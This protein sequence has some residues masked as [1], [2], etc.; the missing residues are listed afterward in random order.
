MQSSDY[1]S[2]YSAF[3]GFTETVE[4]GAQHPTHG[5]VP[6]LNEEW[7]SSYPISLPKD[8]IECLDS[9]NPV[10]PAVCSLA[11]ELKRDAR[12]QIQREEQE[13]QRLEDQLSQLRNRL[14]SLKKS[15]CAYDVILSPF[16]RVPHDILHN[17]ALY[18][19]PTEHPP[20]HDEDVFP[21]HMTPNL[22]TPTILSHTSAQWRSTVHSMSSLWQ[23]MCIDCTVWGKASLEPLIWQI[24]R[25]ESLSKGQ[26]L[27]ILLDDWARCKLPNKD[28]LNPNTTAHHGLL[29]VLDW[30]LITWT[31]A[32]KRLTKFMVRPF[33]HTEVLDT[34]NDHCREHRMIQLPKI[35]TFMLVQ[36]DEFA[37]WHCTYDL[38]T[39]HL[40]ALSGLFPN[41]QQLWFE[42]QSIVADFLRGSGDGVY[43]DKGFPKA[44]KALTV[45]YF[46]PHLLLQYRD[47]IALLDACPHLKWAS[48]PIHLVTSEA[49]S[50]TAVTDVTHD[51]LMELS[52]TV[53]PYCT[54]HILQLFERLKFPKLIRLYLDFDC[55]FLSLRLLGSTHD[56]H[57]NP[58]RFKG[59]FPSISTLQIYISGEVRGG[60]RFETSAVFPLLRSI[61]SVVEFSFASNNLQ[62]ITPVWDFINNNEEDTLVFPNLC[63]LNIGLEEYPTSVGSIEDALTEA[64][65]GTQEPMA[66]GCSIQTGSA[67]PLGRLARSIKHQVRLI[68]NLH[69]D[70]FADLEHSLRM[71]YNIDITFELL[72]SPFP[73]DYHCLISDVLYNVSY[74]DSY[75][76]RF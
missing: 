7:K 49:D 74:S 60:S 34:F 55:E 40:W 70:H 68:G 66:R 41:M 44:F 21:V 14:E 46:A 38:D 42:K 20:C 71:D 39:R 1:A 69:Q 10:P 8:F 13:M 29:S 35:D 57:Y 32:P 22:H 64:L 5:K 43:P 30:I 18:H 27:C 48:L 31:Q 36:G 19:R 45:V 24:E 37:N 65:L 56:R 26:D 23:F 72:P 9:N 76:Q 4:F 2:Q 63:Y 28:L 52:L 54:I 15:S 16:R 11:K 73:S 25:F 3:D 53:R 33:D 62:H 67:L 58:R 51:G 59:T 12:L 17:I 47:F 61:P 50:L 75:R 6:W